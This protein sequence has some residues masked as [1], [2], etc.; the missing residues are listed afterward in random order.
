V[1]LT[2]TISYFSADGSGTIEFI[3]ATT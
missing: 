2:P 3:E 1:R